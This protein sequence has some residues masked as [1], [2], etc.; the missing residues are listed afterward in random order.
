MEEAIVAF[1][2]ALSLDPA[3]AEAHN[4]LGNV[5]KDQAQLS[6]ALA[7]Y[8]RAIELRP[9]D[10][11]TLSNRIYTLHFHTDFTPEAILAEHRRWNARHAAPLQHKIEPL[12]NDPA[13]NRRL[14][15]GYIAPDFREHC[16][17]LFTIPL[18][19]NH[20]HER[21]EIF[22]YSDVAQPDAVTAQLRQC[23]DVWRNIVGMS[24]D[25]VAETIRKDQIDILV[26]LTVHMAFNR[27][28]VLAM[29]P[30]PVQA[31]WLAYPA[32]TGVET[33]DYRLSDPY[34]DP[35]ENDGF[36]S[37]ETVRLPDSYWCYDPMTSGPKIKA[38]PVTRNGFITFGCLNNFCKINDAT[39]ELWAEVMR[40]VPGS[41]L[42]LLAPRGSARPQVLDVLGRCG[43]APTRIDFTERM[44][45]GTYLKLYHRI[46]IGLDTFPYNGHTTSLD[47]FWMG[48]PVV[49]KLGRA[50]V[51]RAGFSQLSNLGLLDL[52]GNGDAEFVEIARQLS[53]N[54]Q[55]LTHLRASLR[56][57]LERSPLMNAP[58]FARGMEAAYRQM[59]ETWS[60]ETIAAGQQSPHHFPRRSDSKK[61]PRRAANGIVNHPHG[62]LH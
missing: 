24:D 43:I 18:F 46:D 35:P 59:W 53:N 2:D 22:C 54:L 17:S 23:A 11:A 27:L 45:R 36:Y 19:S 13:P 30:A 33:I 42:L 40:E 28:R 55:R 25:R 15:I 58:R 51:G 37:E 26:D 39:L 9:D 48:V 3:M 8:D 1:R 44:H 52:C 50:A 6:E 56:G 32:T 14:R 38:A 62:F 61:K 20:D 60:A 12:D 57:M 10:P 31:S 29:K 47:A 21:F 16:Q 49:T 4:N 7:C 41:R 34:L 5:L